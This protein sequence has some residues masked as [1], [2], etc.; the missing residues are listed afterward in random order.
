MVE[1]CDRTHAYFVASSVG[2]YNEFNVH[3][4]LFQ[5]LVKDVTPRHHYSIFGME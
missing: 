4:L 5:S 3:C 2:F 1:A